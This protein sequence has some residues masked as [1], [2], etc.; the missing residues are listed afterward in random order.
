MATI[1]SRRR[2]MNKFAVFATI[3]LLGVTIF[4]APGLDGHDEEALDYPA[5]EQAAA[6]ALEE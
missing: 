6:S 5:P 3:E 4:A 2:A 1:I